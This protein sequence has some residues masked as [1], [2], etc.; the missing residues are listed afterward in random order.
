MKGAQW[1][2]TTGAVLVSKNDALRKEQMLSSATPGDASQADSV[3][4]TR[5][6]QTRNVVM[7]IFASQTFAN[8]IW[9]ITPEEPATLTLALVGLGTLAFYAVITGWRPTRKTRTDDLVSA[10]EDSAIDSGAPGTI[11]R[12]AA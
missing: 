9:N 8:G 3:A 1:L 4:G 11:I 2:R 5:P 12:R 10:A 6:L 7:L